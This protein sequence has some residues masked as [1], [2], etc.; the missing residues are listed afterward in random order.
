MGQSYDKFCF[1]TNP[2]QNGGPKIEHKHKFDSIKFHILTS[3]N[4]KSAWIN[5]V[6]SKFGY[7]QRP[8][9]VPNEA[10]SQHIIWPLSYLYS[11]AKHLWPEKLGTFNQVTFPNNDFAKSMLLFDRKPAIWNKEKGTFVFVDGLG[12][13]NPFLKNSQILKYK[14]KFVIAE[15]STQ[16][17]GQDNL[18]NSQFTIGKCKVHQTCTSMIDF[19][20]PLGVEWYTRKLQEMKNNLKIDIFIFTSSQLLRTSPPS[21][22]DNIFDEMVVKYPSFMTSYYAQFAEQVG[23]GNYILESGYKTQNIPAFIR[24]QFD[25]HN[26]DQALKQLIPRILTLSIA[27]YQFTIPELI[28]IELKN[29]NMDS[30]YLIKWIQAITFMPSVEIPSH[31]LIFTDANIHAAISQCYRLRKRLFNNDTIYPNMPELVQK[32]IHNGEPIIRPMWFEDSNYYSINDQYMLGPNLLV[33]PIVDM[34]SPDNRMV[35]FPKGDWLLLDGTNRTFGEKMFQQIYVLPGES[36]YFL[37]IKS[38]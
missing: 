12:D 14:V 36:L 7:I 4:I 5:S 25:G 23:G 16:I 27:G 19:S 10:L 1:S 26:M 11:D 29:N 15:I 6:S 33:A 38:F 21:S 13:L 30:S 3:P 35:Y 20:F 24:I 2:G 32:W 28:N 17:T 8:T 34:S 18:V 31:P 37:K 9:K 22:D